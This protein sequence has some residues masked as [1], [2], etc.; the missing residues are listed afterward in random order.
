MKSKNQKIAQISIQFSWIFIL[1]A[2]AIIL[3]FFT[4]IIYKQ[5]D[6]SEQKLSASVLNQLETI[7]T[8]SGLS[9]GTINAID[10]PQLE[11]GFLCDE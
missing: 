3:L 2:G 7:L 11:L 8:S 9:S 5:K 1:I 4:S 6:I 10:T